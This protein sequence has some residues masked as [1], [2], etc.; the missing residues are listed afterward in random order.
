VAT[1][2][3]VCYRSNASLP[4]PGELPMKSH[5]VVLFFLVL[6]LGVAGTTIDAREK[7]A[8]LESRWL[9]APVTVDGSP[10]DWPGPL[11]PFNDEP[12]SIAASN[13]G[14]SVFLVLTAS[15]RA[16]R[17][18][19]LRRGLIVWFDAGG[20]DKKR[21]GVKFPVGGGAGEEEFRGRR[22]G[23]SAP[24]SAAGEEPPREG[25]PPQDPPIE[26]PN[27]LELLGSDKDDARSFTADKAPG[28]EVKVAQAEG[29]LTYE[30]KVPLAAN[31][32]HPYAIGSKPGALISV[33]LEM[34][35]PEVPDGR[36][37]EGGG[38]MGPGGGMGGPGGGGMGGFGGMGGRGGRPH[39]G[40]FERAEQPKPLN[41]WVAV[42]LAA[43]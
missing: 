7:H 36:G 10:V 25:A 32:A 1:V 43:K 40:D 5:T 11:V 20:K 27:R 12:I 24:G 2:R 9:E 41:G 42:Q 14:E 16:A 17:M 37:R 23:G 30:L 29:L 13:D 8:R 39:G 31:D 34:P 26:P 28:I 35:K 3:Q 38:R 33:G 15:D 19:I 6:V 22:R 18:Q 21:F 4:D